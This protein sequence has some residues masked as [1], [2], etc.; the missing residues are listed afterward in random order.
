MSPYSVQRPVDLVGLP[1]EQRREVDLLE[2]GGV[3]LVAHHVLDVAE[4]LPPQREP[5]EAAGSGTPDV[6]GTDQQAVAGHLGVG[7]VV[8]EGLQEQFRHPEHD[9]NL[10]APATPNA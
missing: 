1:G 3:H 4:D 10:P 8:A 9:V 2:A 5:R 7:R 6:S